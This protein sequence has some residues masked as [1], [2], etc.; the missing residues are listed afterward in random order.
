MQRMFTDKRGTDWAVTEI[1]PW[2]A[3]GLTA[4]GWLCFLN[5]AGS[6]VRVSRD[7]FRGDW[8]RLSPTELNRLL[9]AARSLPPD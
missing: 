7:A 8:R 6:R 5:G 3:R 1:K 2:S 9:E 4:Q